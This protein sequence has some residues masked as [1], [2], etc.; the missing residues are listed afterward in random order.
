MTKI[1]HLVISDSIFGGFEEYVRLTEDIISKNQL[2]EIVISKL[3]YVLNSNKMI[4]LYNLLQLK[5]FHIHDLTFDN[6]KNQD[7]TTIYICAHTD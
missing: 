6:I 5:N 3:K 1:I 4:N 7:N 2:I